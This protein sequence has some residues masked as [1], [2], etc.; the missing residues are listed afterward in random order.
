MND[1]AGGEDESRD[2]SAV[3]GDKILSFDMKIHGND[4]SFWTRDD[5]RITRC[6]VDAGVFE[7]RDVKIDCFFGIVRKPEKWGDFL[8]RR[9][10]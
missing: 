10:A 3:E 4:F 5:I 8:H 9:D 6:A 2:G 1:V 7:R